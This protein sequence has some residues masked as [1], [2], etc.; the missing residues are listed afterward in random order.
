LVLPAPG[1]CQLHLERRTESDDQHHQRQPQR[2]V[3]TD[4]YVDRLLGATISGDTITNID[5]DGL[6]LYYLA[7]DPANSYLGDQQYALVGGGEL[8]PGSAPVPL[9]P[10]AWL[11]GS[12]LFGMIV[13][14][15]RR[16]VGGSA[17]L[18]PRT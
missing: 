1:F 9:P 15:R 16:S 2:F 7:S 6:N 18:A 5:G 3:Y 17:V 14:A 13:A 4:G 10:A 8:M 11:F 12:G